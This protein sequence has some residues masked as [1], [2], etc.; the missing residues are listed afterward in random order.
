MNSSL[1]VEIF[2]SLHEL[3]RPFRS[4][5]R[6]AMEAVHP[7]LTF[8]EMRI[9]MRTG[10]QPGI[11]QK[12]L[13]E[14]SRIDKAQMARM[15]SRLQDQGWLKR[16]AS[17]NDKRVRCLHLS[18]QG[19][20]LFSRLRIAQEDVATHLLQDCPQTTQA[21]LLALVQQAARGANRCAENPG[22]EEEQPLAHTAALL[23]PKQ[24]VAQS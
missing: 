9:L 21:Q 15:L 23:T 4:C 20:A 17:A 24:G 14:H 18:A 5:M 10:R 3:L 12:E 22:C 2:D 11:T 8:N 6:K 19:Q 7:E 16:S 13:V 1:P